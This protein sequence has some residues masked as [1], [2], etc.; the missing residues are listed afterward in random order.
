MYEFEQKEEHYANEIDAK[1]EDTR[2]EAAILQVR[3]GYVSC[4][5]TLAGTML[6]K[7]LA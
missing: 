3:L 4:C 2:A 7:G 1:Q 5:A 6:C